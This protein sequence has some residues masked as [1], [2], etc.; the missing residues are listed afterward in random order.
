MALCARHQAP[1]PFGALFALASGMVR[2]GLLVAASVFCAFAAG[3][4][5]PVIVA[6][7]SSTRSLRAETVPVENGAQLVVFFEHLA[8]AGNA[9][10]R[11]REMPL[12]AVLRDT[13]SDENPADDRLRQVWI[14]TYSSPSIAQRAAAGIP[15]FYHRSGLDSGSAAH[16]PRPILD[17]AR[18]ARGQW[19]R[20]V[21]A[22]TQAEVLD[23]VGAI[24]RLTTRSYGANLG[25]YRKTHINEIVNLM[26]DHSFDLTA[27]LTSAEYQD[28]S[29]RLILNQRL[30]G[31]YVSDERLPAVY[32]KAVEEESENR[33]RNRELL[34]QVAERDG[35]YFEPLHLADAPDSFGMIWIAQR[36]ATA[37]GEHFFDGKFLGIADPF[38][39]A[40]VN[41]W[42]GYSRVWNLD[43][44]G[45]RVPDGAAGSEPARMIPLAIYS[46]DYPGVPLPLVDFRDPGRPQR[47]EM[48]LRLANDITTGVLGLTTFGN[49]SYSAAKSGYLYV[50]KRHGGPT[51][52]MSR[53]SAFVELRHALGVDDSLDP[54]LRRE[55]MSRVEKLD[56]DPV[57]KS[58]SQ[59]R[60][61]AWRQYDALMRY[62]ADPQGLARRVEADRRHEYRRTFHHGPGEMTTAQIDE[63]RDARRAR[64]RAPY[65]A[66][67]AIIASDAPTAVPVRPPAGQ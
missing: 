31:G 16:T 19:R 3:S 65:D 54:E 51:D 53:R 47:K 13:L 28:L 35:L 8:D 67:E 7:S 26:N 58:W 17:M 36:D 25:E 40:R 62:A 61:A 18:P 45:V 46:L 1:E 22:A 10:P 12:F 39:D 11:E 20:F 41:A 43:R 60:R 5:E 15:F 52:R 4:P 2:F 63:L 29:S 56:L 49:L 42:K 44:D 24:A 14:F 32:M 57:E 37:P 33:G 59:E 9:D 38:Q 23:P 27:A 34:R 48:A 55:L 50:Y 6:S 21:Y 30:L 64:K 66:P